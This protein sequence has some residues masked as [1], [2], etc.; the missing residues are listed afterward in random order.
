LRYWQGLVFSSAEECKKRLAYEQAQA[1]KL[2]EPKPDGTY[3]DLSCARKM[4][5]AREL[6]K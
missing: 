3:F 6:V 1:P 5:P 2:W 4:I